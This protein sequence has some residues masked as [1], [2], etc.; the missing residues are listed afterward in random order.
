MKGK[1]LALSLALLLLL[2]ACGEENDADNFKG[3]DPLMEDDG[4]NDIGS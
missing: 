1:F 2:S 3:E 4:T